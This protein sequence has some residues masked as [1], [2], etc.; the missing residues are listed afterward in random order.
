MAFLKRLLGRLLHWR[1]RDTN[2][3]AT[4]AA[5]DREFKPRTMNEW[6]G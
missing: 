5:N 1:H 6:L 4:S 2:G 3:G